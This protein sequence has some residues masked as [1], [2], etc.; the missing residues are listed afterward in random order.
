MT[1][2]IQMSDLRINGVFDL[3]DFRS[4]DTRRVSRLCLELRNSNV[5]D[6][7]N[8]CPNLE[9]LELSCYVTCCNYLNYNP[10]ALKGLKRLSLE[11]GCLGDKLIKSLI[12][13]APDLEEI[14]GYEMDVT[15]PCWCDFI[16]KKTKLKSIR[17]HSV[18]QC[19]T[20][21]Q[22]ILNSCVDIVNIDLHDIGRVDLTLLPRLIECCVH[23]RNVCIEFPNMSCV[24]WIRTVAGNVAT[25]HSVLASRIEVEAPGFIGILTA[26]QYSSITLSELYNSRR[27]GITQAILTSRATLKNLHLQNISW[28]SSEDLY[29]IVAQTVKLETLVLQSWHVP[30]T[31]VEDSFRDPV[32][33]DCLSLIELPELATDTL[34]KV[35]SKCEGLSE[36]RL[37]DCPLVD[38][39]MVQDVVGSGISVLVSGKVC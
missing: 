1:K 23:L 6:F 36:C 30:D 19:S 31:E 4:L 25:Q 11:G 35:L 9:S 20:V 17:L 2:G 15:T 8:K 38:A 10:S 27:V 33:F 18:Y 28:L 39:D 5:S 21:F 13:T 16:E 22:T 3:K 26:C 37:E 24:E 34:V 14:I 29:S 7:I 12:L 32:Q